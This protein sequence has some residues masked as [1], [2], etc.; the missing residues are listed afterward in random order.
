MQLENPDAALDAVLRVLA[1]RKPQWAESVNL[2]P[3]PVREKI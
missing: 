3:A 1:Q 2:S